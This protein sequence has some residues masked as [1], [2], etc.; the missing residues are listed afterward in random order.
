MSAFQVNC[1]FHQTLLFSLPRGVPLLDYNRGRSRNFKRGVQRNFKRGGVQRNFLQKGGG[2]N[3]L[4]GSN[5]Y[6]KSSQKGWG[7]GGP[8]PLDTPPGFA[9]V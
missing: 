7:G 5:L 2:S 8:D 1:W 6:C 3:H 4:L 9:P